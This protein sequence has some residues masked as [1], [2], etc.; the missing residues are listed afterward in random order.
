MKKKIGLGVLLTVLLASLAYGGY[1]YWVSVNYVTTDDACIDGELLKVGPEIAGRVLEIRVKEGEL[2]AAGETMAR[3]EEKNTSWQ[4]RDSA[5]VRSPAA[6]SVIKK[7]VNEGEQA[8]P[9]QRLFLVADLSHLYVS[10]R[11]EETKIRR[12]AVGQPV[13]VQVDAFPGKRLQGIVEQIGLAADSTFSLLP[14]T[15]VSGNFIKVTQRIPVKIK[16]LDSQG[17]RVLPG[18]NAVVKIATGG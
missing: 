3:L 5:L 13:T 1:S 11:I 10:A 16:I 17:L 12:L 18:M 9:G 6:G 15:N 8:V 4:S 7:F 14:T 2:V